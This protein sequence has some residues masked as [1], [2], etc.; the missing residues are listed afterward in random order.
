[1]IGNDYLGILGAK[2][3]IAKGSIF[4]GTNS[5]STNFGVGIFYLFGRFG[6]EIRMLEPNT[7]A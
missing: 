3:T 2:N 7:P 6:A 5:N 4:L 1:L